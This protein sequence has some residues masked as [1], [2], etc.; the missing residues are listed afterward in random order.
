MIEHQGVNETKTTVTAENVRDGFLAFQTQAQE[1]FSTVE[2]EIAGYA[3][4]VDQTIKYLSQKETRYERSAKDIVTRLI[5]NHDK[6]S[7]VTL[8][9]FSKIAEGLKSEIL[10]GH[11]SGHNVSLWEKEVAYILDRLNE[12]RD[13]V[14][15][16]LVEEHKDSSYIKGLAEKAIVTER[17]EGQ[18]EIKKRSDQAQ[19]AVIGVLARQDPD[20]ARD[21]EGRADALR[22]V[23]G[24]KERCGNRNVSPDEI[25]A[26]LTPY[27]GYL[28]LAGNPTI[29]D[30]LYLRAVDGHWNRIATDLGQI[31]SKIDAP[32]LMWNKW[33]AEGI[34]PVS[35]L[36]NFQ[37]L[38][39]F[40]ELSEVSSDVQFM[41]I[42]DRAGRLVPF[43][44]RGISA[45]LLREVVDQRLEFSEGFIDAQID[46]YLNFIEE[47]VEIETGARNLAIAS[48]TLLLTAALAGIIVVSPYIHERV[49]EYLNRPEIGVEDMISQLSWDE[50]L[51]YQRLAGLNI[52]QGEGSSGDG[53]GDSEAEEMENATDIEEDRPEDD[54]PPIAEIPSN[55]SDVRA[56]ERNPFPL[57]EKGP[58]APEEQNSKFP[59]RGSSKG[60]RPNNTSP[61]AFERARKTEVWRVTGKDQIGYYREK[62][63]TVL[64]GP[65][66]IWVTNR[67][68][69]GKA[70]LHPEV[71]KIDQQI[72]ANFTIGTPIIEIPTREGYQ[73]VAN[74]GVFVEGLVKQPALVQTAD[75]GYILV[76]DNTDIGKPVGV[77]I[78]LNRISEALS[79]QLPKPDA[80]EIQRMTKPL[81]DV[82]TLPQQ[83]QA[84][85]ADLAKRTNLS[86]GERAKLLEKYVKTSFLYSLNEEHSDYYLEGENVNEFIRRI[87]EKRYADC[88]VANTALIGIL[89]SQGIPSRLAFGFSNSGRVSDVK[90][91]TLTGDERH[92]W[93]E[94]YIGG[95][96][97]RLD[98]TPTRFDEYTKE[99]FKKMGIVMPGGADPEGE[100]AHNKAAREARESQSWGLFGIPDLMGLIGTNTVAFGASCY[101]RRR[102]NR[103]ADALLKHLE[104]SVI[105]YYGESATK[106]WR[107]MVA[108]EADKIKSQKGSTGLWGLVP[109]VGLWRLGGDVQSAYVLATQP[110]EK[111]GNI[112]AVPKGQ[113]NIVEYAVEA[114]GY[115]AEDVEERLYIQAVSEQKRQ[116]Y[117]RYKE[118]LAEPFEADFYYDYGSQGLRKVI[119]D[120]QKSIKQVKRP[121]SDDDLQIIHAQ[122]VDAL[123]PAYSI[124][125]QKVSV[126]PH[127]RSHL[128]QIGTTL[129]TTS[130]SRDE[131][132]DY[133]QRLMQFKMV[134]WDIDD[135]YSVM[136][137]EVEA[138]KKEASSWRDIFKLPE[139]KYGRR[140]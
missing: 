95:R 70:S 13:R 46:T 124:A 112:G 77:S 119:K 103:R 83:D 10:K 109:P 5:Y 48:K 64:N 41:S 114:L 14:A 135:E 139:S 123:F 78:T 1:G 18:L 85:L 28:T 24:L 56:L 134:T 15:K 97:V 59:A 63:A 36:N 127:V 129:R 42:E 21:V 79:L 31:I 102:N 69:L 65:N 106:R 40:A 2:R 136:K 105:S 107:S 45:T 51:E 71:S 35:F 4:I 53:S 33:S 122:L 34:I 92:G 117:K 75:G 12:E 84:F 87:F 66:K 88:D 140:Y 3:G 111:R 27:L 120:I 81:V 125:Y 30:D 55:P 7:P 100:A 130:L 132:A 29:V 54:V 67:D 19:D 91:G 8:E 11:P 101:L 25:R 108:M 118:V 74:G 80:R 49:T 86:D 131:F 43:L 17:T 58:V 50:R 68:F 98:G 113:P 115:K 37:D 94:A 96:W 26:T 82:K 99:A 16:Q 39:T 73:V 44:N 76:F 110:Y 57:P 72:Y 52:E 104:K 22:V 128:A 116:I 89:R 9:Y 138:K 133:M 6:F 32:D 121:D 62:S 47:G 61:E 90:I 23:E 126:N 20:L 38:L 93:V 60:E 137:G